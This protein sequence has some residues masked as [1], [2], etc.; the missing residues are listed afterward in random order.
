MSVKKIVIITSAVILGLFAL[1]VAVDVV[2]NIVIKPTHNNPPAVSILK[3]RE[4]AG[5]INIQRVLVGLPAFIDDPKLDASATAKC[6]DMVTRNYYSHVT[7]DGQQ[8]WIF[9]TEQGISYK[10]AGENIAAGN[11]TA[12][13]LTDAWMASPEHK[14]NILN[15]TFIDQ[16][17]AV[18]H[19]NN[20]V[21]HGSEYVI[22]QQF[23]LPQ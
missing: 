15:P 14:A 13:S 21:G 5:Q 7:P 6:T 2:G 18:C 16:G 9:F 8:P 12:Q 20:F 19:S 11:Y 3:A 1:L 10:A 17:T 22:V 4:V 23:D